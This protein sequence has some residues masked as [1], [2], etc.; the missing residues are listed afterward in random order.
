MD[1]PYRHPYRTEGWETKEIAQRA[2]GAG[3]S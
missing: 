3:V 2:R 1:A